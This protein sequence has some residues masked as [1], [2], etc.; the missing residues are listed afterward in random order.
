MS[1]DNTAP[2]RKIW[3]RESNPRISGKTRD[4]ATRDTGKCAIHGIHGRSF[5]CPERG[6][7]DPIQPS[8]GRSYTIHVYMCFDS[9]E[10]HICASCLRPIQSIAGRSDLQRGCLTNVN[11]NPFKITIMTIIVCCVV[12]SVLCHIASRTSEI[13]RAQGDEDCVVL[14]AGGIPFSLFFNN[15]HTELCMLVALDWCNSVEVLI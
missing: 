9:V 1:A 4:A 11:E 3:R 12:T 2:G 15:K 6:P 5:Y 10:A 14:S 13:S 8:N 7:C